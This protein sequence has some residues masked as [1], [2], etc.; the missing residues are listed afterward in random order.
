LVKRNEPEKKFDPTKFKKEMDKIWRNKE[1][2]KKKDK[3][4]TFVPP[5]GENNFLGN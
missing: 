3:S 4:N 1:E 2:P 5:F